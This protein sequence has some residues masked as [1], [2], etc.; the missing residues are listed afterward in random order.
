MDNKEIMEQNTSGDGADTMVSALFG[1]SELDRDAL[2]GKMSLVLIKDSF[3]ELIAEED[4]CLNVGYLWERC[5]LNAISYSGLDT[6][7][8]DVCFNYYCSEVYY[9]TSVVDSETFEEANDTFYKLTGW[10]LQ[11]INC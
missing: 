4:D 1:L 3:K 8:C 2:F 10:E 9:D 11:P 7:Y 6:G 5:I